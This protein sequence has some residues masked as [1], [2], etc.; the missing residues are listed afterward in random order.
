MAD[1]VDLFDHNNRKQYRPIY[2]PLSDLNDEELLRR[3]RFDSQGIEF[4]CDLVRDQLDFPT[5]KSRALSVETQ[6]LTSLRYLASGAYQQVISDTLNISQSSA[7]RSIN[8]FVSAI[9][10]HSREFI[11]LPENLSLEENYRGFYSMAGFPRVCGCIDGTHIRILAPHD[12]PLDYINRKG[13]HSINI[14]AVCDHRGIFTNIVARWP[15]SSHDSWILRQSDLWNQ[16]ERHPGQG[17][18]LGDAGYPCRPWLLTPYTN[19]NTVPRQRFN[20]AHKRTR[21][22]IEQSFGRWKRRFGILHSEIRTSPEK[23]CKIVGACAILHNI[24]ILRNYPVL[25]I[26]EDVL[27]NEVGLNE[28][29]RQGV[30]TGNAF[31]DVVANAYFQ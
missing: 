19:P 1:L 8:R 30:N 23:V 14:Q 3:Y 24:A 12:N 25:D 15:G 27:G 18:L 29:V 22:L 20:D 2:D 28:D 10:T 21:V 11:T 17:Y 16:F 26:E 9:C 13:F 4:L 6:V 31:R 7:S 5:R